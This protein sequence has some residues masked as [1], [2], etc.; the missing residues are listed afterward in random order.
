[1]A[2]DHADGPEAMMQIPD[3]VR[4]PLELL[5]RYHFWLL[6]VVV[7]LVLLPLFFIARWHLDAQIDSARRQI[8]DRLN[9]L[10]AVEGILPHPN[11]NWTAEVDATT[12]RI[13]RETFQEWTRFW[14]SEA[15]LRVWPAS[16]G[17]DFVQK[18]VTLKPDGKLSRKLLERYQNGVREIV[19][20]LPGRMGADEAMVEKEAVG[21]AGQ[22]AVRD[23]AALVSWD[24]GDQRRIFASFNWEKPP[25][26]QQVVLAQ[27]ELW[28]YGLLC[29]VI[30]RVNKS[31]AGRYNAPIPV[32]QQLAVGYPAAEESPGGAG[33]GRIKRPAAPASG[34]P[35]MGGAPLESAAEPAAPIA[36]AVRP[37]HPRFSGAG[38][39]AAPAAVGPDGSATGEA[40]LDDALRNWIYVDFDGN[41]QDSAAVKTAVESQMVHL[42]PFVL[43]IV[44]D[45]RKLDALLVEMATAE[46]PIDVRQLRIN[47]QGGAGGGNQPTSG[48]P[49]TPTPPGQAGRAHDIQVELR[50][51]V[52]L[53]TPPNESVIGLEP[54]APAADQPDAAATAPG[55][56]AADA[57]PAAE[58]PAD[59]P[60]AAEP[61]A[62]EP[63][64]PAAQPAAEAPG[65]E[66]PPPTAPATEAPPAEAPPP[67]QP[68]AAGPPAEQPPPEPPPAGSAAHR[69]LKFAEAPA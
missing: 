29:D 51:T 43:R 33:T 28:V 13:K 44:I 15:R 12:N 27:E 48:P 49:G 11:E 31:A 64:A 20:G 42:M 45:Q 21:P 38:A 8:E 5:G 4:R 3:N 36:P 62:A 52:G 58:P 65:A 2:A 46:W 10:K 59:A 50:G 56:P 67:Q 6:A 1:L 35:A 32:V 25:S 24:E 53:A 19:R 40:S 69:A 39:A 57:P 61:P 66:S 14:E 60:P 23:S 37:A 54:A 68:P 55:T 7:P 9:G 26:T 41:P 47:A 16:L 34:Q 22:A 30:A 63:P 17:D 18:A